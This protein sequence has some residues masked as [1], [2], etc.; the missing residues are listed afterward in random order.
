MHRKI[1]YFLMI[2]ALSSS[3]TLAQKGKI[4]GKVTDLQTGDVLIGATVQIAGT[5]YGAQ[6]GADGDYLIQNLDPGNYDLK[7]SYIGYKTMTFKGIRVNSDLNTYY[8]VKLPSDE[9]TVNTVEV[10]A[11]RKL[12]Q[13]SEAA[14]STIKTADDIKSLPTR[15]ITT[16][17]NM[18]AGVTAVSGVSTSIRGGRS[19]QTAYY[20]EGVQNTNPMS[21]GQNVGVG[22]DAVEEVSVQTGGLSA[23]YGN[24]NSGVIRQNLKS[25]GTQLKS[26]FEYMTDNVT[27]MSLK[28]M[29]AG[30]KALGQ[31]PS[32]YNESSFSLS[33]P[34]FSN[35]VRFFTNL[36]YTSSRGGSQYPTEPYDFG[37]VWWNTTPAN[38]RDT[39][40]L[41]WHAGALQKFMNQ[42][43]SSTT[44]MNFDIGDF[45]VRL[46][47][48]F[49]YN[50]QNTGASGFGNQ[51]NTRGNKFY[52]WTQ[53]YSARFTHILSGS[54]FYE[55]NFS[56]NY[57][58]SV[59]RDQ[60]LGEDWENFGSL[61]ANTAAGANWTKDARDIALGY[62][63][64]LGTYAAPRARA[65]WAS[66]WNGPDA[67]TATYNTAKNWGLTVSGTLNINIGKEHSI[68]LGGEYRTYSSRNWNPN[69]LYGQVAWAKSLQNMVTTYPTRTLDDLKTELRQLN[70]FGGNGYDAN[71]NEVNDD[72]DGPNTPIFASA[73]ITD[74]IEYEDLIITLGLRYDYI[75]P[76]SMKLVDPTNPQ[77]GVTQTASGFVI[78][79]AGWE[80]VTASTTVSPRINIVFPVTEKTKFRA[81]Y[82]NYVQ[83]P[84]LSQMYVRPLTFLRQL[85]DGF[86]RTNAALNMRPTRTTTYEVGLEQEVTDFL[87]IQLTGYY[88]DIKDELVNIRQDVSRDC[89]WQAYITYGN[90]DFA[91]TKGIELNLNM[92]RY[93]RLLL[94]GSFSYSDARGT[95]SNPNSN[96]GIIGA[97]IEGQTFVP[98]YIAPLNYNVPVKG[99]L[100]IDYRFGL[101]EGGP[102]FSGFGVSLL[103]SYQNGHPY[104]R[105]YGSSNQLGTSESGSGDARSRTALEPLNSSYTPNITTA[106]ARIDKQFRIWDR[107]L[108][109]VYLRINNVFNIRNIYNVWV[110]SGSAYDNGYLSDPS[111]S[112]LQRISYGETW[113]AWQKHL[114]E[115]NNGFIGQPRTFVLGFRLD[116]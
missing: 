26:S 93:Q 45:R 91:T 114:L 62:N 29:Y 81:T 108:G 77:L 38:K 3:L 72:F 53:A 49:G 18:T 52:S 15:S 6:T 105:G 36:N 75:N 82:G 74:A 24:A 30:K 104:T 113:Y 41:A 5:T 61:R 112:G 27:F 76:N 111:E 34:L 99:T 86:F 16:V 8:D 79:P 95:G 23:E 55:L 97:P 102:V 44:T 12:I 68:R 98:Q 89:P 19:G 39:I 59:N 60:Y 25:G 84:N 47:G 80:K 2:L 64:S 87:A 10:Y 73:F 40:D 92:R 63:D 1:F 35:D 101:D 58:H 48:I 106:D 46:T 17:I 9:I 94:N 31:Y 88:R 110:K 22:F 43:I 69:S 103:M 83:M 20:L 107:I 116:Y 14:S 109:T 57:G 54:M 85:S 33:G 96:L 42:S 71:G 32:G 90:G 28:D 100:N 70:Y 51:Y 78:N 56:Y 21:M 11:E 65:V 4:K 37:K 67:I 13:K 115:Y 7:V 50:W 66:T